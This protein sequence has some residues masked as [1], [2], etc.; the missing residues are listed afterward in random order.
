MTSDAKG[1]ELFIVDNSISGWTGL[2]YL[3]EWTGIANQFD[4][5]TG[6]FE[7][8]SLLAMG[9]SWKQLDKIRILMGADI[10]N[11]TRKAMLEAVRGRAQKMLDEGLE[12][13]KRADPLLEGVAAIVDAMTA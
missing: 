11:R 9:D 12:A 10:T 4:I 13:D 6:F 3:D 8:G 1:R 5:A 7:L 2:R